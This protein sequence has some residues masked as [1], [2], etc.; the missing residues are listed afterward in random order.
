MNS[1]ME[2][3]FLGPKKGPRATVALSFQVSLLQKNVSHKLN[4]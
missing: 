4:V 3:V 1:S 2:N